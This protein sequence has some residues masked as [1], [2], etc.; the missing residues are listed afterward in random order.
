MTEPVI[1]KEIALTPHHDG[2]FWLYIGHPSRL[3]HVIEQAAAGEGFPPVLV[4]ALEAAR[5]R[6][7]TWTREMETVFDAGW[8]NSLE[9]PQRIL[10]S[11]NGRV[12]YVEEIFGV[13]WAGLRAALQITK[14]A[15]DDR[16]ATA[17]AAEHDRRDAHPEFSQAVRNAQSWLQ[18]ADR[19]SR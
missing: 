16:R 8:R 6:F 2:R 3:P 5:R 7:D 11:A 19:L 15:V 10:F 9:P 18:L 4:T 13:T 17:A 14:P 12:E 1:L